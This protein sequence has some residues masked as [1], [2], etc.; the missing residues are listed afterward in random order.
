MGDFLFFD[1]LSDNVVR[2]TKRTS[3]HL[4][5]NAISNIDDKCIAVRIGLF[6]SLST[7]DLSTQGYEMKEAKCENNNHSCSKRP[8]SD[9]GDCYIQLRQALLVLSLTK[10]LYP[11][12]KILAEWRR[13]RFLD[14]NEID[15]LP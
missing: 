2:S 1:V 11:K 12:P 8:C 10:H 6:Q 3:L 13:S 7:S 9:I 15:P 14:C 5:N 4:A